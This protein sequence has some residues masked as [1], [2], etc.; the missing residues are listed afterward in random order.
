MLISMGDLR[1]YIQM[2]IQKAIFIIVDFDP[3]HPQYNNAAEVSNL[4]VTALQHFIKIDRG[5]H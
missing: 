5:H 2:Y 4:P 3:Y 1:G